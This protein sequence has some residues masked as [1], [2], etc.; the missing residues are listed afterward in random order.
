MKSK[1]IT[2]HTLYLNTVKTSATKQFLKIQVIY[3]FAVWEYGENTKQFISSLN[4]FLKKLVVLTLAGR[5][6]HK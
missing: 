3:M 2:K 5:V 4:F 1:P 6:F